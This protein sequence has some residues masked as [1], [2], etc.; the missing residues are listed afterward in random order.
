MVEAIIPII[1]ALKPR[2]KEVLA[3]TFMKKTKKA[4]TKKGMVIH[5]TKLASP[6]RNGRFKSLRLAF[7]FMS[8]WMGRW[9]K[10][11]KKAATKMTS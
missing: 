9:I 10:Y 7:S 1:I 8:S 2:K 5:M 3:G 4:T 11:C 6:R